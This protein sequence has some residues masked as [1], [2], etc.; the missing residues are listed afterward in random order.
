MC[1]FLQR[2]GLVV[3]IRRREASVSRVSSSGAACCRDDASRS[4]LLQSGGSEGGSVCQSSR[5]DPGRANSRKEGQ[6]SNFS[7]VFFFFFFF[8]F[9]FL[10]AIIMI[11]KLIFFFM[12]VY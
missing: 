6:M 7:Y 10:E 5:T 9:F 3:F 1:V 12:C 2:S 11:M 4:H 8:F